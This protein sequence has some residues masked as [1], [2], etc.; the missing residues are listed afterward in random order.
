MVFS[1][2]LAAT[3][4][5]TSPAPYATPTT[6]PEIV[7]VTTTDRSSETLSN[8]VRTTYVVTAADITRNGYRTVSDALASLPGVQIASY[9]P[10][11]ASSQYG[12]RGSASTEVLVLIDGQPTPG[13]FADSVQLGTTSTAGVAR[14]EVV[15]GGGSTLYGTGAIG[16]IINIITNDKRSPLSVTLSY[17]SFDDRELQLTAES[18]HPRLHNTRR[19]QVAPTECLSSSKH[20]VGIEHVEYVKH[21]LD[22]YA[23]RNMEYLRD[24]QICLGQARQVIGSRRD[25]RH[26]D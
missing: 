17:G 8:T 24:A 26:T 23:F 5:A 11:G 9:G 15:E 7:H 2:V 1:A 13:G 14:I 21:P 6:P 3:L 10:I 22:R 19:L 20:R 16:G 25:Q 4:A 12:I 18:E